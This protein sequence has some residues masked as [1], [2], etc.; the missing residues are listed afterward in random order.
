[1]K[2][3]TMG[4]WGTTGLVMDL[5]LKVYILQHLITSGQIVFFPM[6]AAAGKLAL[7][8]AAHTGKKAKAISS[9]NLFITNVPATAVLLNFT[10][11]LLLAW[12]SGVILPAAAAYALIFPITL[13]IVGVCR[14]K[15]GGITGDNLGFAAEAGEILL[16]IF[17]VWL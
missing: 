7:A 5:G 17:L 6:I 12:Y 10:F 16:G 8:L 13:L 2:D 11:C 9:A 14:Q 1:M 4:S 3:P 15:I